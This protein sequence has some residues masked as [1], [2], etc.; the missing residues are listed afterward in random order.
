MEDYKIMVLVRPLK[1]PGGI[2]AK[3]W[4]RIGQGE[5]L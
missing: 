2:E 5:E 4:T 1:S 3:D